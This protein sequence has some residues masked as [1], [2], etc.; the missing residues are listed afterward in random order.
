MMT[1]FFR[2]RNEDAGYRVRAIGGYKGITSK[3]DYKGLELT[4][5]WHDYEFNLI[6]QDTPEGLRP[7]TTFTLNFRLKAFPAYEPFATGQ[8]GQALDT[9]IGQ[10]L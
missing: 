10:T 3:F 9:G 5:S 7:G 6:Y 8:Y 4:R 2:V 1:M